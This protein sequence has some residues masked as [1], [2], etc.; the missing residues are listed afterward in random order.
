VKSIS[1]SFSGHESAEAYAEEFVE[2]NIELE[3]WMIDLDEWAENMTGEEG[4]FIEDELQLEEWMMHDWYDNQGH[5]Q[6]EGWMIAPLSW[7]AAK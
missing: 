6:I 5:G 1:F 7:D 2:E 3:N 4:E